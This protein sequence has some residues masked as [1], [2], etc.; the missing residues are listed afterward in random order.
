[1][2]NRATG[3]KSAIAD[4]MLKHGI[5]GEMEQNLIKEAIHLHLLSALS[6]AGVLRHVTFQGGTA[7]RL[8]YGA[9]RYSEDLDFVC[10]KAGSYLDN[11]EFE[12]LVR[13]AL[14]VT[15]KSLHRNF[16]I[17]PNR[18]ALKHPSHPM[19]M[20]KSD[21]VSVTAWQIVVPVG[22]TPWSPKS[23]VNIEFANVPSYD[24]VPNVARVRQ[25]LVQVQDVILMT[26]SA[27]EILA[28][29]AVALT[30]RKVLK[31][32]DVWDAW[33]LLNKLNAQADRDL[34]ARK[35]ADY[36]TSDVEAKAKQRREDLAKG[37]TLKSFLD[38]MRRF[39]PAKRIAEMNSTG[40][41]RMILAASGELIERKVLPITP[42]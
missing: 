13:D 40:L 8:C 15:K 37:S 10:G 36:G 12:Q 16:D 32:R 1:M 6:D 19:G 20:I 22:P 31:Y 9:E 18:I 7:L 3:I 17:D 28:D 29:K 27:N 5:P 14:E 35:F 25:G 38:E 2:N 4:F 23:R 41:H 26:E 30:A 24:G 39:L 34:V 42:K 33:Y 11:V 21:S